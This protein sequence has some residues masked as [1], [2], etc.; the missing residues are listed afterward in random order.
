ML[1]SVSLYC[2][3]VCLRAPLTSICSLFC[4][5]VDVASLTDVLPVTGLR[6]VVHEGF[7]DASTCRAAEEHSAQ[8]QAAASLQAEAEELKVRISQTVPP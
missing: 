4:Y 3:R 8:E 2:R 1:S 7:P 6:T 5:C